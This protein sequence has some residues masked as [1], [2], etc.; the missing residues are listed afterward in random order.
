M[1]GLISWFEIPA[2]DLERAIKFYSYVLNL[3]IDA[4]NLLNVN[5]GVF[6][7]TEGVGGVIVKRENLKPG[8][9]PVLYLFSDD[10]NITLE[11]IRKAGGSVVQKKTL[12]KLQNPDG[13]FTIS[14]TLID[15]QIG[16]YALFYDSEGNL[17][18]L[19][20]NS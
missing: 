12:I 20:S 13:N 9:G 14:K 15:K 10:I 7:E 18:A 19:H 2:N 16:Y 17:M 8:T 3:S 4:I 1:K 6:P 5:Y 11:R